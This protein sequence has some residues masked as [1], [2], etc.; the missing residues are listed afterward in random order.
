MSDQERPTSP[1]S[2]ARASDEDLMSRV[3][4][5]DLVAFERLVERY[6]VGVFSLCFQILR[7]REDAEEASQD[8]FVKAFR[9]RETYDLDRKVSPWLLRIAS[10]AARDILRKRQAR[11]VV[12][13]DL[14]AVEPDN[15]LDPN[16]GAGENRLDSEDVHRALGDLSEQYRTPLVLKYLHGLTN[17]EIADTI[18][19]SLS[20][21]KVRLS[22]ARELLHARLW[23]RWEE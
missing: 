17:Q 6:K 9:A 4:D 2:L 23:K 21:L 13:S 3:R 8:A 22:R 18:G 19:V 5:G 16:A 11:T 1:R 20:S 12:N 14:L 15:L 10:N 7:S